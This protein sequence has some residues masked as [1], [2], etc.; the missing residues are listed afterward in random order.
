MTETSPSAPSAAWLA[1]RL[2]DPSVEGIAADV[3]QL[4]K[5]QDLPIHTRLP[6]VRDLATELGVSPATVSAAWGQ[7]RGRGLIA[8]GGRAGMHVTGDLS[9]P[10]PA[11]ASQEGHW[12]TGGARFELGRSVPDPALLPDLRRALTR[13]KTPRLLN[14]YAREPIVE[15]LEAAA[16]AE[17]PCTADTLMVANGGY[18]GLMLIVHTFLHPGDHVLVDDP[19]TPRT[20][21]L[22]QARQCRI[23]FLA[24]DEEGILPWALLEAMEV[25]PA[26]LILQPGWHNPTGTMMSR[27]RRDELAEI[28]AAHPL[29]VVEDDGHGPLNDEPMHP[30]AEVLTENHLLVRSYSKSHGPDLRIAMIEGPQEMV[31]RV[32]AFRGFGSGWTSRPLQQALAWMLNDPDSEEQVRRARAIYAERRLALHRELTAL[33]MRL[34]PGRGLELWVPVPDERFAAITL[35]AHQINITSGSRFSSAGAGGHVRVSTGLLDPSD[36]PEVAL[37]LARAAR[38]R[39]S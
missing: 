31:M 34:S 29:L 33:G 8:G 21:D 37:A 35:A 22:L 2:G 15:D 14:D 9:T 1:Q 23:H 11:L 18:E 26:A 27:R 24:R 4:I 12:G 36:A 28:I 6:A 16:R 7:L 13:A 3:S 30:L 39:S 19:T 25:R 5:H 32:H 38:L 17:W 10:R 20:R